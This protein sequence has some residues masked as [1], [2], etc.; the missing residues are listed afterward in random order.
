MDGE[1]IIETEDEQVGAGKY[2]AIRLTPEGTPAI[3]YYATDAT[4]GIIRYAK[5]EEAGWTSEA[6]DRI[7]IVTTGGTGARNLPDLDY[8]PDGNAVV[9]YASHSAVSYT[10]LTLPTPPYV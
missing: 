7:P 5:K 10:H 1:C 6:V 9:S 8:D 4:S 2:Q 3:S